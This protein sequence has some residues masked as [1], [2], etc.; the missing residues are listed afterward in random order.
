MRDTK[1][2]DIKKPQALS[3]HSPYTRGSLSITTSVTSPE[4]QVHIHIC[5]MMMV[6]MMFIVELRH[7]LHKKEI[8]RI[9]NDHVKAK[10]LIDSVYLIL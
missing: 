3:E 8:L 5:T 4:P 6:M 7:C 9:N 2:R 1:R 10:F